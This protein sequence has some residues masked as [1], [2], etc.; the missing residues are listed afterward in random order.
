M[1]SE[2]SEDT[3]G[4]DHDRLQEGNEGTEADDDEVS[5][6][7]T[8]QCF[9][10]A[11]VLPNLRRVEEDLEPDVA[12]HRLVCEIFRW[13]TSWDRTTERSRLPWQKCQLGRH[14]RMQ[15]KLWRSKGIRL[16]ELRDSFCS[17]YHDVGRTTLA[18][19]LQSESQH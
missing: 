15:A 13:R 5:I 9:H 7:S 2:S 3:D 12:K 17:G 6:V 19:P 18:L 10:C 11:E 16:R 8:A 4:D 1:Q 14:L